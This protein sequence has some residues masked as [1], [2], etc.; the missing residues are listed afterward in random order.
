MTTTDLSP[1]E[2]SQ[3]HTIDDLAKEV[4]TLRA[5]MIVARDLLA[6]AM[7]A[8]EHNRPT[9]AYEFID[10]AF[11]ALAPAVRNQDS[12]GGQCEG[13]GIDGLILN[14]DGW[15]HACWENPA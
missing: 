8:T 4:G 7:E 3:A 1:R 11:T 13:C 2:I 6:S 10:R 15:C 9:I 14:A 12:Q 5:S